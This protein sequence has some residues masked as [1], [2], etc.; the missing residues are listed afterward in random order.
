MKAGSA[1]DPEGMST[2]S[3]LT[4][5]V[6]AV[7]LAAAA[8][9][10][11][12]AAAPA[13]TVPATTVPVTTAAP[14]TVAATTTAAP[15]A[16]APTTAAAPV[17]DGAVDL[18]D[19]RLTMEVLDEARWNDLAEETSAIY[20]IGPIHDE[21]NAVLELTAQLL[22]SDAIALDGDIGIGFAAD[23]G[24]DGLAFLTGTCEVGSFS[25]CSVVSTTAGGEIVTDD[26]ITDLELDFHELHYDDD[27]E[28]FWSIRYPEI[29]CTTSE[30][31]PCVDVAAD[32][33]MVG[34]VVT[35]V[36]PDGVVDQEWDLLDHLPADLWEFQRG[37]A[38]TWNLDPVHC[39]SVEVEDDTGLLL[40]STRNLNTL[41]A[42]DVESGELAWTFGSDDG[43]A[44]LDVADPGGLL[45][46]PGSEPQQALLS[47]PHHLVPLGDGRYSVFDNASDTERPARVI[48]FSVDGDVATIETV[49]EDATGANSG[50]AGSA[51]RLGES[52]DL[53]VVAWGC[54]ATGVSIMAADGTE[55]ARVRDVDGTADGRRQTVDEAVEL[56]VSYRALVA[57]PGL[58]R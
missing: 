28:G 42:L 1:V 33:T 9:S 50:C 6:A 47:A 2:T 12:D 7:A 24:A 17:D 58:L 48:V 22:P 34:C 37:N 27:G 13:T 20:L 21:D 31:L 16:A 35:H 10:G 45:G 15:T 44:A 40:V 32:E 55:I 14:T 46:D 57:E 54:S 19:W 29:D 18:A 38:V 41:F 43:A 4:L 49:I 39:N 23:V 30:A 5:L 3:R 25:L 51:S 11:S 26:S 52:D 8:C 56:M 53:W 36:D